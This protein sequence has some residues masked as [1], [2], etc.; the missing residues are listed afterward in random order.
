M[1]VALMIPQFIV[2]IIA[3]RHKIMLLT[4][5]AVIMLQE[6][7]ILLLALLAWEHVSTN[8]MEVI[9]LPNTSASMEIYIYLDGLRMIAKEPPTPNSSKARIQLSI[10][11]VALIVQHMFFN[12]LP[13]TLAITQNQ[14]LSQLVQQLKT[15]AIIFCLLILMLQLQLMCVCH[16]AQLTTNILKNTFAVLINKVFIWFNGWKVPVAMMQSQTAM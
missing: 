4:T 14:M 5:T 16:F 13:Q 15:T 2:R 9:T 7:P 11:I 8:T 10:I 12:L 3:V 6:P 1:Q